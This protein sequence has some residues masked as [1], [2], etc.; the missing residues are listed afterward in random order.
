MSAIFTTNKQKHYKVPSLLLFSKPGLD[1]TV[2]NLCTCISLPLLYIIT[3]IIFKLPYLHP[4]TIFISYFICTNGY[5]HYVTVSLNTY[6]NKRK[7]T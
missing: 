5:C 3:W 4:F 6:I 7:H 2:K 1:N